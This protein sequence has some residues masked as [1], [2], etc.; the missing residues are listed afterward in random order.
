MG[1]HDVGRGMAAGAAA[2]KG[3]IDLTDRSAALEALDKLAEPYHG[4]DA[5]FDDHLTPGEPLFELVNAAFGH[6]WSGKTDYDDWAEDWYDEV[7][8]QARARYRFC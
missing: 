1:N 2:L 5:E 3:L 4:A 6:D 7:W 8:M